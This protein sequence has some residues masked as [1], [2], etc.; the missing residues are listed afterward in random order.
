MSMTPPSWTLASAP[1]SDL[2]GWARLHWFAS[3]PLNWD[4]HVGNRPPATEAWALRRG[5]RG[6]AFN[7]TLTIVACAALSPGRTSWAYTRLG[8]WRLLR[9]R[10]TVPSLQRAAKS[11]STTPR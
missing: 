11:A 1:S 2:H 4:A 9:R 7:V 8:L 5:L 3:S 6:L 10:F